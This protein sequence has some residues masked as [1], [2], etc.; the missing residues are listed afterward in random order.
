MK[1]FKSE[2]AIWWFL[3]AS[4]AAAKYV[5]LGNSASS[6]YDTAI[7]EDVG[8]L[9]KVASALLW[10]TVLGSLFNWVYKL[11]SKSYNPKIHLSIIGFF[12][13]ILITLM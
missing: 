7:Y 5:I 3:F 9:F 11:I 4:I 8:I 6:I 10:S 13:L 2:F 1:I 12:I